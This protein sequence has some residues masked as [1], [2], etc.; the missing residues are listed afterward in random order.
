M[1]ST[2]A[3]TDWRNVVAFLFDLSNR[4]FKT[5]LMFEWLIAYWHFVSL[6]KSVV[7]II[8]I[9]FPLFP[10]IFELFLGTQNEH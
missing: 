4:H 3:I 10:P 2:Q 7:L 5:L 6:L 8:P 1:R 9:L